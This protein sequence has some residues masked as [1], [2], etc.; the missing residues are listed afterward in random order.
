[1]NKQQQENK[2]FALL[3]SLIISS[4][5]LSIG[6]SMLHI[7]IKQLTLGTTTRGSEIAFQVA[8]AGMECLRHVRANDPVD[9]ITDGGTVTVDCLGQSGTMTD[10]D[11]DPEIQ[12][13]T[14]QFDWVT[15]DGSQCIEFEAYVIDASSNAV[16]LYFTAEREAAPKV[17]ALGD[18]CSVA[19]VRGFNRS[20][21]DA[22]SSIFTVQRELS[23]E[24]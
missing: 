20:C 3:L 24:F 7:T 12:D 15:V 17:C 6:L 10:S 16:T 4:I 9:Y 1:M 11:V 14:Y 18:I 22:G 5:A 21:A 19:F 13:F 23:I 2:G 8:S